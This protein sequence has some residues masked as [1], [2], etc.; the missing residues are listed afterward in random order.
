MV[1]WLRAGGGGARAGFPLATLHFEGKGGGGRGASQRP[2]LRAPIRRAFVRDFCRCCGVCVCS[3]GW[4]EGLQ[5]HRRCVVFNHIP[6][7]WGPHTLSPPH[8][9]GPQRARAVLLTRDPFSC[10]LLARLSPPRF[11]LPCL[12]T[13][14]SHSLFHA[15]P[16]PPTEWLPA[17]TLD[18]YRKYL[19]GIKGPL[20]TPIGGGIRSLNVA[21]RQE[22]DLYV[23]LRP[24]RWFTGVPSPV[25]KPQDVDMVIFRENTEVCDG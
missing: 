11:A 3:P 16:F 1:R 14:A 19:V 15:I 4:R 9:H 24:V 20:T 7:L 12:P 21:L 5:D 8:P 6:P 18:A 13:L 10:F 2:L 23:C 17:A 22:L 25:K